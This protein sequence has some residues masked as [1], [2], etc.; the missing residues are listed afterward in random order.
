MLRAEEQFKLIQSALNN[1]RAG[2]PEIH[3]HGA[4]GC[5]A[6]RGA[7]LCGGEHE[8]IS[9]PLL[10]TLRVAP[11]RSFLCAQAMMALITLVGRKDR[12][13]D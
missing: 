11:L 6:D 2:L 7:I 4:D 10:Q 12:R 5:V 13:T 1:D 8:R 9:T 3:A